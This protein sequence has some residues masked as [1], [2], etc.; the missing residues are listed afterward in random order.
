MPAVGTDTLHTCRS[1]IIGIV[2][3]VH[4]GVPVVE[5]TVGFHIVVIAAGIEIVGILDVGGGRERNL[6]AVGVV[7][8]PQVLLHPALVADE[9][10]AVEVAVRVFHTHLAA[11][12]V[13]QRV[14][15]ERQLLPVNRTH[16]VGGVGAHIVGGGVMQLGDT[17]GEGAET[18]AVHRV[19]AV[20]R[21]IRIQTPAETA[22]GHVGVTVVRY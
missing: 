11:A 7:R 16:A 2:F 18:A 19:G 13:C 9:H 22:G 21:G 14:G 4:R 12:E 8:G 20:Q 5:Q 15:G 1:A 10:R 3:P 17:V 6:F